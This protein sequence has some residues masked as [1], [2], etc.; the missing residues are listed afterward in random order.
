VTEKG[1][2]ERK[3]E[4]ERESEMSKKNCKETSIGRERRRGGTATVN[5]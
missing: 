2:E 1:T 3:S 4:R 5:L